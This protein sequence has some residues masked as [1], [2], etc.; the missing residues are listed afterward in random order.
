MLVCTKLIITFCT[1]FFKICVIINWNI[2]CCLL[3]FLGSGLA[4]Y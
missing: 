2:E 3:N 4:P 1:T